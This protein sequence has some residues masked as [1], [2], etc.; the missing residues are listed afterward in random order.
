[1]TCCSGQAASELL[2]PLRVR[3]DDALARKISGVRTARRVRY[4]D[5]N[6][7]VPCR[8]L[9]GP[10]SVVPEGRYPYRRTRPGLSWFGPQVS[11][12]PFAPGPQRNSSGLNETT[13]D[14]S[15]SAERQHPELESAKNRELQN[16]C[17]AARRPKR[18]PCGCRAMELGLCCPNSCPR[19]T[20]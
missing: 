17:P 20:G 5:L 2:P 3:L 10:I 14:A 15:S 1:M 7:T 8:S 4:V 18:M 11:M 19:P 13:W 12:T 16:E 6:C 9:C